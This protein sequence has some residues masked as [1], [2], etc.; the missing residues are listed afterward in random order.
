VL[1]PPPRFSPKLALLTALGAGLF[2]APF[3]HSAPPAP[4]DELFF[5][6]EFDGHRVNDR[7]WN[8]RTGPCTGTGTDGLNLARNVRVAD[9]YPI[10]AANHETSDGCPAHTGGGLI[11]KHRFGYGDHEC[12][13]QPFLARRGVHP[14]FWP[15]GLGGP[16]NN[17]IFEID[18]PELDSAQKMACNNLSV[19]LS[20]K[21]YLE[22]AGP[23]RAQVPLQLPPDRG[24]IDADG[25]TPDAVI[26]HDH[27]ESVAHA[28]FP[29]LVA[30]QNV[31]LTA[32]TG[33]GKVDSDQ[34]PGETRFDHFRF[35]ARDFPGATL[36]ANGGFEY[37][38]GKID[39]PKPVAWRESGD[40][41]ARLLSGATRPSAISNRATPA[42]APTSSRPR[43]PSRLS[44]MATTN[45]APACAAQATPPP[46]AS[47][48]PCSAAPLSPSSF[49]P[50]PQ[51]PT[52][53]A[54]TFLFPSRPSPFR[55][56]PKSTPAIGSRSTRCHS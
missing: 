31:W 47:A 11:S 50:P 22:L 37:N 25:Y 23:H 19:D 46:P 35:Y 15:R 30:Q 8:F 45:S 6:D 44:A 13:S 42:T 39:L 21:G 40:V 9:G 26:F 41:A 34:P 18:S 53:A 49:P 24:W 10:V 33:F 48:S 51:G 3:A 14:A 12:R 16:A 54:R 4:G 52:C 27:G 1:L 43:R 20:P 5:A 17:S 29:D 28:D 56:F 38:Q 55:S 7:D 32:L 2:A 36:L